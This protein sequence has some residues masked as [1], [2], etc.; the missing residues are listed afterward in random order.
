[1]QLEDM[2][3]TYM[4]YIG[5]KQ[6]DVKSVLCLCMFKPSSVFLATRRLT[7]PTGEH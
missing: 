2:Y 3:D 1:M 7:V 5:N 4:Y 6:L